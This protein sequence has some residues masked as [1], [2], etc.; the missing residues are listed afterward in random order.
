MR[1]A[2]LEERSVGKPGQSVVISRFFRTA[3]FDDFPL[4]FLVSNFK[5]SRPLSDAAF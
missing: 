1:Q 4:Q 2:L 5:L 3:A